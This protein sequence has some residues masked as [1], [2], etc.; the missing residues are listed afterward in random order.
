LYIS[1]YFNSASLADKTFGFTSIGA[2]AINGVV[3]V[4]VNIAMDNIIL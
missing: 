4:I 1:A 2:C 3:V